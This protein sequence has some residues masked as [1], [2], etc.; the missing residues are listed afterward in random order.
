MKTKNKNMR[1]QIRRELERE[2]VDFSAD[3]DGLRRVHA[4]LIVSAAQRARYRKPKNAAGSRGRMF[5]YSLAR[6]KCRTGR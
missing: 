5:F 2:G 1:C 3:Y 4:D 6:V